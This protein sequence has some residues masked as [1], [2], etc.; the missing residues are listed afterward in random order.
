MTTV[1]CMKYDLPL[2]HTKQH[3]VSAV[4]IEWADKSTWSCSLKCKTTCDFSITGGQLLFAHYVLRNSQPLSYCSHALE[5][6]VDAAPLL[7][8]RLDSGGKR[9]PKHSAPGLKQQLAQG[10]DVT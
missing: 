2:C 10:H 9:G 6:V 4:I 3:S 8:L 1:N 5:L 7:L